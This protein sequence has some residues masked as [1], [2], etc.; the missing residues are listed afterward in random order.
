M[1]LI[2]SLLLAV[3]ALFAAVDINNAPV[4]ELTSLKGIGEAKAKA[5]VAYRK[6]Q[7]F[8]KAS[9]LTQV[10]GIGEAT[11]KKN[12]REITVGKCRKK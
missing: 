5:I 4:K 2:L 3:G 9:D 1:K 10:K 12:L 6:K 7:C 8:K 11:V